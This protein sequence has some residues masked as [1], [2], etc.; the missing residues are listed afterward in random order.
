MLTSLLKSSKLNS[1]EESIIEL[2]RDMKCFQ[3]ED[4]SSAIVDDQPDC[5]VSNFN[6]T[7]PTKT[8]VS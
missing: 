2:L 1:S 8:Q 7:T 3:A 4:G 5:N 6:T